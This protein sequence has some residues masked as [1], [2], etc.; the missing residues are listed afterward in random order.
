MRASNYR[1]FVALFFLE[2]LHDKQTIK[3]RRRGSAKIKFKIPDLYFAGLVG[4]GA[5]GRE[6]EDKK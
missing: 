2:A 3:K 1:V 6:Q 5:L 4:R